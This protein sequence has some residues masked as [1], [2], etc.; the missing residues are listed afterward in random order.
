M[1]RSEVC[2]WL[3][4]GLLMAPAAARNETS[5]SMNERREAPLTLDELQ[6]RLRNVELATRLVPSRLIRRIIKHDRQV[7]GLGLLVPHR[8]SYVIARERLLRIVDRDELGLNA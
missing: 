8:K 3:H 6:A 4:S 1:A 7:P 5:L 2:R